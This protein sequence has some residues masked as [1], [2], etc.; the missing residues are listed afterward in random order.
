MG[1]VD[2]HSESNPEQH[3]PAS[4]EALQSEATW[5]E[6]RV[7]AL[8]KENRWHLISLDKL[9]AVSAIHGDSTKQKDP[10][11]I[12]K[13]V[14]ESI[15]DATELDSLG[16]MIADRETGEFE[17]QVCEPPEQYS[18]LVS[19]I[20]ASIR[21]AEFAWA[22]NYHLPHVF[23]STQPEYKTVLSVFATPSQIYG[24]LVASLPASKRLTEAMK[25]LIS[26]ILFNGAHAYENTVLYQKVEQQ[27][28]TLFKKVEQSNKELAY[29]TT[30]DLHTGLLN[31]KAFLQHIRN[32]LS[33]DTSQQGI[34]V[35]ID[36]EG[37][38]RINGAYSFQTGHKLLKLIADRLRD[39]FD[40][41]AL[42]NTIDYHPEFTATARITG[43]EFAFFIS[44]E[45][46]RSDAITLMKSCLATLTKPYSAAIASEKLDID[47]SLGSCLIT[48]NTVSVR[49]LLHRA[50]MAMYQAKHDGRNNT[51]LYSANTRDVR[52]HNSLLFEKELKTA[53]LSNQFCLFYQAKVSLETDQITGAEALLRWAHPTRGILPP[54]EFIDAIETSGMVKE[55]GA[56][57]FRE[58]CKQV[59]EW[60][61]TH[62]PIVPI[63]I[64]LSP[65]QIEP[66]LPARFL[67]IL[68]KEQVSARHFELEL[69]ESSMTRDAENAVDVL[70]QLHE[71]GFVIAV[72]DFGTGYSSLLLLKQF[73]IDKLKIDRSFVRDILTNSDDKAIVEAILAM[74]QS[75][76][77][78]VVAEGIEEIAQ[79][80]FLKTLK[81]HEA[82]GYYI[83]K[84]CPEPEFQALLLSWNGV[85]K[86]IG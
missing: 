44:G 80:N 26:V 47:F 79:Y 67:D 37:F 74:S 62:Q 32:T 72:D 17:L 16:L 45:F 23:T 39:L 27:R 21:Q 64:N 25:K 49:T 84:P 61:Q 34:I 18:V 85:T 14:L 7:H 31:T 81:C 1:H 19:E 78:S 73:P 9:S 41:D 65:S 3:L 66:S 36:I 86:N 63:A 42:K 38:N 15:A 71:I 4:K 77:L 30:H 13:S 5:L 75:L 29:H 56:W 10:I 58:A 59:R 35:Y 82:Q 46:N 83:S 76:K 22:L 57:V 28:Q 11:N 55:V 54:G 68:R 60:Q 70:N 8:E 2:R 69:T 12:L 43:D 52:G 24:M 40:G 33:I 51:A 6:K 20:D 50:E 48:D 53:Y